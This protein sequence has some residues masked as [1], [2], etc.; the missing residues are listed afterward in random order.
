[1]TGTQ[2]PLD[3]PFMSTKTLTDSSDEPGYAIRLPDVP[4]DKDED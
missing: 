1:M 4:E 3:G 2:N